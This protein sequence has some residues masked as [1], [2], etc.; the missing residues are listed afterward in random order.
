[1]FEDHEDED[2][3]HGDRPGD[4]G[5]AATIE[6]EG[7]EEDSN[8]DD[9][10]LEKAAAGRRTLFSV[11]PGCSVTWRWIPGGTAW[12]DGLGRNLGRVKYVGIT[13]D[14]RIDCVCHVR[15]AAGSIASAES[16]PARCTVKCGR[17]LNA[18]NAW[19]VVEPG[20]AQFFSLAAQYAGR[21]LTA[22]KTHHMAFLDVL[23]ERAKKRRQR[24]RRLLAPGVAAMR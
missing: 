13:N 3:R 23:A 1:M 22:E 24:A 8:D 12:Q 7:E 6:S 21:S 15:G 14:I 2:F 5:I 11:L 20:L 16:A 17:I 18:D 10:A 9:A 19:D 4:C